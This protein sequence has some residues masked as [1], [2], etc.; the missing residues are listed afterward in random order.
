M[1]FGF[2]C[3]RFE[4]RVLA[5]EGEGAAVEGRGAVLLDGAVV[6]GGGVALVVVPSVLG[7]L[8]VEAEH[9]GVAVGFG[10]DAG[11]SYG[12]VFGVALDDTLEGEGGLVV[13]AVAVD[14]EELW[15]AGA[16]GG[17][18]GGHLGAGDA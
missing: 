6:V 12:H 5:V 9:D 11:G 3:L 15:L 14:D 13:E 4:K 2:N 18:A 8:G 7:V 10:K 16:E 1:V 17:A